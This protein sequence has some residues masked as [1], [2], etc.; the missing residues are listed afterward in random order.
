MVTMAFDQLDL[1]LFVLFDAL[2][3]ALHGVG[4]PMA[5]HPRSV[6]PRLLNVV[7]WGELSALRRR[8][9]HDWHLAV[10]V[11]A[12]VDSGLASVR[13][14]LMVLKDH[15]QRCLLLLLLQLGQLLTTSGLP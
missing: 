7:N 12:L 11:L 8:F 6:S 2:E 1:H 15:L 9:V 10:A 4:L 14:L 13:N 5:V 3:E